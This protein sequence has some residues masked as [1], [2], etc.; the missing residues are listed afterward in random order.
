MP[1]YV[2]KS[3]TVLAVESAGLTV[4]AESDDAAECDG[5]SSCAVKTLCRGRDAGRMELT[6]PVAA[7]RLDEYAPGEKVW[8][9]YRGANPAVASLVMFLPGLLGVVFGGFVANALIAVGDGV[10]LAGALGGLGFGV[11]MTFLLARTVPALRAEA[12]LSEAPE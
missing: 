10:F 2:V 3:A 11:A 9:A 4:S 8:V 7:G 1:D 12:V 5:C 6:V